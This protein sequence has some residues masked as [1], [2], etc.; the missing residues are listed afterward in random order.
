MF[1]Q[2][3]QEEMFRADLNTD[4]FYLVFISSVQGIMNPKTLSDNSFSAEDAFQQIFRIL[5][6]GILTEKGKNCINFSNIFK[7]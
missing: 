3:K 5:M 1:E 7:Q 4:L 2:A 6:E